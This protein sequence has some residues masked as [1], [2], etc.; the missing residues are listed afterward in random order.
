MTSVF[1]FVSPLPCQVSGIFFFSFFFLVPFFIFAVVYCSRRTHF[2]L[3]FFFLLLLSGKGLGNEPVLLD[4]AWPGWLAGLPLHWGKGVCG[5]WCEYCQVGCP[6]TPHPQPQPQAQTGPLAHTGTRGHAQD[7]QDTRS[8]EQALGTQRP[9]AG[10]HRTGGTPL[11][12]FFSFCSSFH[13]FL[14]STSLPFR[15]LRRLPSPPSTLGRLAPAKPTKRC[16]LFSSGRL[17]TLSRPGAMALAVTSFTH[18]LMVHCIQ[19]P[20]IIPFNQHDNKNVANKLTKT[21]LTAMNQL[22]VPCAKT[23]TT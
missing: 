20:P 3:D 14:S 19:H 4:C 12:P 15:W 8:T 7:T 18:N 13:F 22:T 11:L 21:P 1:L 10:G 9:G 23:P 16:R 2:S 17:P 5:F 6:R